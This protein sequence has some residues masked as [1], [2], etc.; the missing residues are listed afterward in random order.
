MA[1]FLVAANTLFFFYVT[2]QPADFT[3]ITKKSRKTGKNST[4]AAK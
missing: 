1:G 3:E 4:I 2:D